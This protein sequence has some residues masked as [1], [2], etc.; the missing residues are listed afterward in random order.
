M[1]RALGVG[2]GGAGVRLRR[3]GQGLGAANNLGSK[4]HPP[5]PPNK[6]PPPGSYDYQLT[7]PV[8]DAGGADIETVARWE[9]VELMRCR[10]GAPECR[11]LI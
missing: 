3:R 9:G 11:G 6:K 8:L 4:K 10:C 7:V 5:P 1:V 2:G